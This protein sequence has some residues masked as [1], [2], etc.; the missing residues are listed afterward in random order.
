[1]IISV[2]HEKTRLA[3]MFITELDTEIESAKTCSSCYLH[4]IEYPDTWF[5]MACDVPHL[6]VWVKIKGNFWPGKLMSS[7]GHMV[8]VR[9]F[10]DHTHADISANSCYLYTQTTPKK[11]RTQSG[12]FKAALQVS[13]SICALNLFLQMFVM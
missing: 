2:N 6:M 1:M 4:A 11:N 7:D 3:R 5:Q 8:N 10:G 9:F 12:M 13:H